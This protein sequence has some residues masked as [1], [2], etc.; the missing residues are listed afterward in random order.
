[1]APRTVAAALASLALIPA[2]ADA[3]TRPNF[4]RTVS[5]TISG[6]STAKKD[7]VTRKASWTVKGVRL[8]LV[9]VRFVENTLYD[10]QHAPDKALQ[11]DGDLQ[12]RGL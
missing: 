10:A 1:M 11:R 8:K 4:P 2:A 7:G 6:S 5:G 3:S 9:H 12:L